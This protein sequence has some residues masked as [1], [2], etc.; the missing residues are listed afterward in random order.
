[1]AGTATK[2]SR[3][4][5]GVQ[6]SNGMVRI[7]AETTGR[8]PT[9]ARTTIARDHVI[10]MLADTLTKGEQNLVAAG[11]VEDVIAVRQRYQGLMRRR[12]VEM[13]EGL[14]DRRVIGFMSDNNIAP[15]L[16]VEIFILDPAGADG[17]PAEEADS[18]PA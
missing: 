15:D 5:V 1:M 2:A 13:V 12:A 18:D 9:K 10:V 6:I 16:G 4:T 11:H 14:L 17:L 8:G 7:L 3:G